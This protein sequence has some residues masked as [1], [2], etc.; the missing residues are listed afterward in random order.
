MLTIH[1]LGHSQSERIIWLCEKL[2]VTYALGD[3][4][5]QGLCP[6]TELKGEPLERFH[7]DWR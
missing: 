6:W 2:G 3:A 4:E 7:A 5:G 1:H